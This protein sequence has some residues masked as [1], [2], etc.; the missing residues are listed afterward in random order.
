[1]AR[2]DTIPGRRRYKV[3][4]Q[5][6]QETSDGMGGQA[7]AWTDVQRVWARSRP[8]SG[9]DRLNAEQVQSTVTHRMI[10]R[11]QASP[12]NPEMPFVFA[13]DRVVYK[14]LAH[15]IKAVLDVDEARRWLELDLESGVAD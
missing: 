1:M 11:W 3:T 14:G 15:N 7:L 9:K 12:T 8:L 5:R 4:I 2:T 10:I 13:G 6:K